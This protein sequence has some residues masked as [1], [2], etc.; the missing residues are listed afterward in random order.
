VSADAPCGEDLDLGGDLDYMNFMAGAEGLLPKSFFGKDQSGNEG[1]PFDRAAIDFETQFNA[2][3]PFIEKTRDLRMLGV[4]AKFCI[5]NRDFAGFIACVRAIGALLAEHWADVHPRAEDGDFG[6][7]MVAV[8]S[9]EAVPTVILPL[10]F[11]PLV[12][13]KRMGSVSYRN[14]LI[15]KGE[16]APIEGEATIDL[17]T[18]EKIL[19]EIELPTLIERRQQ[20]IDL[21]AALKQIRSVWM[22]NCSSG[23][24]VALDRL[25]ASVS[26]IFAMLN[27]AIVKRDPSAGLTAP[28]VDGADADTAPATAGDI[29][30]PATAGR[31]LAAVA[32]YFSRSEPSSPALLLVRQAQDL[33]GK[34][35]LEVMQ[36]LVPDQVP[37]A[38]INIGKDQFF[39]LPIERL[40]TAGGD[41]AQGGGEMG[42]DGQ[43]GAQ[44]EA[45]TRAEALTLLEQVGLYFRT[46][47]PSSPIPFFTDRA[48]DLATRDFL[49]VLKA[50]LPADALRT[51]E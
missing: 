42:G 1:R 45:R 49:S 4:L 11:L 21:D 32:S 19:Q 15:A 13:H 9:I 51:N 22:E 8:E 50:L 37:R 27:E 14:H 47:E 3:M 33:L 39:D 31:A 20:L 7:R 28:T 36:L 29:N 30:S 25:P 2:A 24:N 16:V 48:R 46:A 40:A 34:S 44:F 23:P 26:G 10:Q 43:D 35:F 12:E 5:L 41:F 17:A 38:A 18:I 6:L